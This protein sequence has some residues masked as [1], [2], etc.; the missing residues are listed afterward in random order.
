MKNELWNQFLAQMVLIFIVYIDIYR[1]LHLWIWNRHC[2]RAFEFSQSILSYISIFVL[3]HAMGSRTEHVVS[4]LSWN[5][6]SKSGIYSPMTPM[7]NALFYNLKFPLAYGAFFLLQR[8]SLDNCSWNQ[9]WDAGSGNES[10]LSAKISCH[11][12][13]RPSSHPMLCT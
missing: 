1:S 9:A 5:F 4:V 10:Q 13:R 2:S 8:F 7:K 6:V 12:N 3:F 11:V